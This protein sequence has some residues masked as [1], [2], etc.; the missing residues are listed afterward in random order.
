MKLSERH[1][2]DQSSYPEWQNSTVNFFLLLHFLMFL[3][4]LHDGSDGKESA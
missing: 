3:K 1:K 4:G 2:N